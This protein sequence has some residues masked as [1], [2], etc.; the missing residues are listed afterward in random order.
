MIVGSC[1]SIELMIVRKAVQIFTNIEFMV[2]GKAILLYKHRISPRTTN[3]HQFSIW[4][5]TLKIHPSNKSYIPL[6]VCIKQRDA[7]FSDC[8]LCSCAQIRI[9]FSQTIIEVF[10]RH[11]CFNRF[12]SATTYLCF[13]RAYNI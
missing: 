4:K 11:L 2:V 6:R 1:T 10:L 13:W 7:T 8:C 5:S 9:L 12:F 3:S